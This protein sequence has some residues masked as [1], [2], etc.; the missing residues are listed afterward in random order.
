M[1]ATYC[2]LLKITVVQLLHNLLCLPKVPPTFANDESE[3]RRSKEP[4]SR[5]ALRAWA[6]SLSPTTQKDLKLQTKASCTD[7]ALGARAIAGVSAN[8]Y[9]PLQKRAP[10]RDALRPI[11]D[12]FESYLAQPGVR[13]RPSTWAPRW[14]TL[15]S[16][17]IQVRN[18][19]P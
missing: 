15:F 19:K 3:D 4:T 13:L 8:A 1:Y 12:H 14:L 2:V 10:T 11:A 16:A 9:Q 5:K 7:S 6:Q 18:T 17:P